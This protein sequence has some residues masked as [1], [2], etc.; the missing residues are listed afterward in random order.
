[1]RLTLNFGFFC[2]LLSST[3]LFHCKDR[4]PEEKSAT[5]LEGRVCFYYSLSKMNVEEGQGR[6]D[7]RD[8]QN[9]AWS[10]S[11]KSLS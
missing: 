2:T 10:R 3:V 11:L 6:D 7:H 4:K 9:K 5:S 8:P 1:M